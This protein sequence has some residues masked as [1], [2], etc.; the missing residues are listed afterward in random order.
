LKKIN[1]ILLFGSVV[2][3]D[4]KMPVTPAFSSFGVW[5]LILSEYLFLFSN[6]SLLT[7]CYQ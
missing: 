5:F 2:F 4:R 7:N 1:S 6:F 3:K